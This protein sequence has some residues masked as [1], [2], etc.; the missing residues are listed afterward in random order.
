MQNPSA[1]AKEFREFILKQN[2]LALAL[3]VVVGAALNGLVKA[4]VDGL[5]MPI[6]AVLTPSGDWEK[7]TWNVGPVHF[8]VGAVLA[9][10]LNFGVIGLVAWRISKVF[11]RPEA[12]KAPT[13]VCDYCR[14]TVDA[15][16]TRCP[17]CT[18]SLVTAIPEASKASA[19]LQA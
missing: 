14:S 18:S 16:A 1:V 7:S 9:A 3:A 15:L 11:I 5:I 13:K 8:S 10:L 12:A 2:V 17:H 6:V 19:Q 4:I